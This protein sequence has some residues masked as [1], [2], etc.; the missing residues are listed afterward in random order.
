MSGQD[1]RIEQVARLIWW[2]RFNLLQAPYVN[3]CGWQLPDG[4]CA[5]LTQDELDR[6]FGRAIEIRT[7]EGQPKYN[8]AAG[9]R[10]VPR[11]S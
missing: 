6:A 11:D 5:V 2:Y 8:Q 3:A 10:P 7:Q 4:A 9:P 1:D